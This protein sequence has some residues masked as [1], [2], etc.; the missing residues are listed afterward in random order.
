M[1]IH[2]TKGAQSAELYPVARALL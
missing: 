1:K 2:Q